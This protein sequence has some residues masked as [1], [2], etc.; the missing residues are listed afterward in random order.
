MVGDEWNYFFVAL[1]SAAGAILGIALAVL[2][3]RDTAWVHQPKKVAVAILA[4]TQLATP[5]LFSLVFLMPSHPWRLAGL[6]V[7][8]A[9]FAALGN[10]LARLLGGSSPLDDADVQQ[11]WLILISVTSFGILLAGPSL[12]WKAG[13]CIWMIASGLFESA[14]ILRVPT[15]PGE[16]SRTLTP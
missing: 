9:G 12:P 4:V 10:Q 6:L 16:A 15:D 8:L 5:L 13:V 7:G 1:A 3:S 2:Q 11:L 14:V